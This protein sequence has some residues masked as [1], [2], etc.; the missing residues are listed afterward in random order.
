MVRV[1]WCLLRRFISYGDDSGDSR[2]IL[3]MYVL[4][5]VGWVGCGCGKNRLESGCLRVL[6]AGLGPERSISLIFH[7]L[8]CHH[9]N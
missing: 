9:K 6:G 7:A 4:W 5:T 8:L 1:D 3:G 2:K